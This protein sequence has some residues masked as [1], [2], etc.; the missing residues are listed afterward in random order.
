MI[1]NYLNLANSHKVFIE[2]IFIIFI[3]VYLFNKLNISIKGVLGFFVGIII[4]WFYYDKI[5]SIKNAKSNNIEKLKE[6]MPILKTLNNEEDLILFYYNNKNL[7]NYDIINYYESINNAKLFVEVY[8]RIMNGTDLAH[9]QYDILEK[10]M[11]L[12]LNH[13]NKI[14]FNVPNQNNVN[15]YLKKNLEILNTILSKYLNKI[16]FYLNKNKDTDVFVKKNDL[17]PKVKEFNK[18]NYII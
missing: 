16:I 6:E 8:N 10:H 17:N 13:F 3:T 14:E 4:A 2:C 11:I 1:Y 12:C 5:I 7:A 18:F 15:I 9:Y